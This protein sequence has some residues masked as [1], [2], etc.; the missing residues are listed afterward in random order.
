AFVERV[1]H[2]P[3]PLLINQL[4]EWAELIREAVGSES[5][6][7]SIPQ[8]MEALT[9]DRIKA[10]IAFPLFLQGQLMGFLL[11]WCRREISEEESRFLEVFALKAASVIR[12]A[13]LYRQVERLKDQLELENSYLEE[14]VRE[15]GGFAD[16]VGRSPALRIVLRLVQQV[17]PTDSTVLLVGET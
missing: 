6:R 13:Q 3:R 15:E 12:S 17:A 11:L 5:V 4:T 16:I 8:I 14:A 7:P 2:D 10:G 1:K 9:E